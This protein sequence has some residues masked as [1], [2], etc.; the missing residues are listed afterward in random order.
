MRSLVWRVC[1]LAAVGGLSAACGGAHHPRTASPSPSLAP[2][3]LQSA[4]PSPVPL[5]ARGTAT[6]A[7]Y[8]P[9]TITDPAIDPLPAINASYTAFMDDISGLFANLSPVWVSAVAETATTSMTHAIQGGASAVQQAHDHGVGTLTDSHRTVTVTGSSATLADCLDEL[10]W[11]VVE[12]STGK[13]DPSVTPGY[14]VGSASFVKTNGQWL[15]SAWN[16]HPQKC[17]P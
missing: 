13:A 6:P 12:D 5:T 10:H 3:G 11:Y 8:Q 7:P 15:V 16:S 14:F 2:L 4:D 1:A 17:T 9:I